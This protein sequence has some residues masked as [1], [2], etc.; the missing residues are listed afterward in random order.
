MKYSIGMN[1]TE[2][3]PMAN[4]KILQII[5]N[6][7]KLTEDSGAFKEEASSAAAKIQELMEK[8]AISQMDVDN[9]RADKQEE[10]FKVAFK[11][12]EAEYKHKNVQEWEWSLTRLIADITMTR[13]YITGYGSHKRYG[14][15][16]RMV[17]FGVKENAEMASQLYTLWHTNIE[18]MA[19][20]ARWKNV[21]E[22]KKKYKGIP[23]FRHWIAE[24]RPDE[25]P[26]YFRSS[27]IR[28]C[29]RAMRDKVW[30]ESEARHGTSGHH[31][32]TEAG[33]LN[34]GMQSKEQ[35][36]VSSAIVLYKAE[37]DK[38]YTE[39]SQGF[40]SVKTGGSGSKGFSS[41]GYAQGHETGSKI[42]IGSKQLG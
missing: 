29:L 32:R 38:A 23:K 24:N 34:A 20:Q 4:E 10:E 16:A 8:Y 37:V 33:K 1:R 19:E 39:L 6:L 17:F 14:G 15:M 5:T 40:A 12:A 26:R 27:W 2:V 41:K 11:S 30:E 22:L 35:Q 25:D 42:K 31:P 36:Q 7:S 18:V 9:F 3:I 21:L 28:G 13:H